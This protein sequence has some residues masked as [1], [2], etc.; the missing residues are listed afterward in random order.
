MSHSEPDRC[1]ECDASLIDDHQNGEVICSGCGIV[2]REQI[3]DNGQEIMGNLAE[4]SKLLRATGLNTYA[5]HDLGL[6]T[7]ISIEKTDCNGKVINSQIAKQ[8]HNLRKWHQRIRVTNSRERRL[9]NILQRINAVCHNMD[10]PKNVLETA[11][12]IYRTYDG[13]CDARGKSISGTAI[14]IVYM[15]CR[16]CEVIRSI[17]D[18]CRS[19]CTPREIKVKSK[20]A[21][22]YY[23]SLVMDIGIPVAP[24]VTVEKY[25]SKISNMAKA[26]VRIERL[27]LEIA[28]KTKDASFAA[29]KSP[30][31]IASACMYIASVLLGH[32]VLQCDISRISGIT[33]VTIRKRCKD[34]AQ[35]YNFKITLRPLLTQ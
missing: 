22:K 29:G 10:L 30:N 34:I 28:E 35:N 3:M 13:K 27:A 11:S 8:M 5:L 21:S 4:S 16:Q 7:E 24:A 2:V 15:A 23:R 1:H 31:G 14:A 12:M 19:I 25:I 26:D 33:E 32:R 18:I 6:V 17:D 20:M 9:S